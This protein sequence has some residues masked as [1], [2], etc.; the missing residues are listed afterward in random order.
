MEA[1]GRGPFNVLFLAGALGRVGRLEE[2]RM[3]MAQFQEMRPGFTLSRF[4]AREPSDSP[5]FKAQRERLYEGL[6]LAGMPE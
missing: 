5:V 6:R 3:R 1:N 2:A 4:R